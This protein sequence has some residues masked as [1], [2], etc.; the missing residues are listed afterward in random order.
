M[1][2]YMYVYVYIC[3]YVCMCI[4]PPLFNFFSRT[5]KCPG[6][7]TWGYAYPTLGITDLDKQKFSVFFF[8]RKVRYTK[9]QRWH[10]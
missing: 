7:Y 9:S 1:Y 8:N 4:F 2:I 10:T 3:M 6:S 5:P